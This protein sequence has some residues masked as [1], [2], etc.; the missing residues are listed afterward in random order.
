MTDGPPPRRRTTKKT[1]AAAPPS[2]PTEPPP[3]DVPPPPPTEVPAAEAVEAIAAAEHE[4]ESME[5]N[6]LRTALAV[7]I[8][9]ISITGA[10]V[11]WRAEVAGSEAGRE[12]R[13]G[14]IVAVTA[15]GARQQADAQARAEARAAQRA[16]EANA[17]GNIF[18][19][20]RDNANSVGEY[21]SANRRF[22]QENGVAI[23]LTDG[24]FVLDFVEHDEFG[25]VTNPEYDVEGRVADLLAQRQT[26]T[27]S[28]RFF[29]EAD[30][31]ESRRGQLYALDVALVLA[32]ALIAIGQV[33]RRRKVAL[34]WAMPGAALFVVAA[35]LF[36]VVEV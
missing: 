11:T 28:E 6:R 32:L 19:R 18:Q 34:A 25:Y 5:S 33:T 9:L 17:A 27:D 24:Y 12:D 7:L 16:Y 10:L 22:I 20:V 31:M 21:D 13:E 15:Q 26:E 30:E 35:A 14:T 29:E 36:V 3:V 8:A 1:T 4:S 2:P 23:K